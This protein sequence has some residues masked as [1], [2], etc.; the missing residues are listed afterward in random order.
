MRKYNQFCNLNSSVCVRTA[1]PFCWNDRPDILRTLAALLGFGTAGINVFCAEVAM[2]K[3]H[4]PSPL[5]LIRLSVRV[6]M[7]GAQAVEAKMVAVKPVLFFML[8]HHLLHQHLLTVQ[9][10]ERP[11][12]SLSTP[13][14]TCDGHRIQTVPVSS[15]RAPSC[16]PK[17]GL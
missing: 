17:V 6:V 8:Q 3:S 10:V 5:L 11:L 13:H 9:S 12:P 14:T 7:P 2:A 1:Y 15:T 4:L 16:H